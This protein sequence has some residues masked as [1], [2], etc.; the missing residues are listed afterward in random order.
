M[1]LLLPIPLYLHCRDAL[2]GSYLEDLPGTGKLSAG[3]GDLIIS[4]VATLIKVTSRLC[5]KHKLGVLPANAHS[6]LKAACQKYPP[7]LFIRILSK[8]N[9]AMR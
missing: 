6:Y 1:L 5:C 9:L 2:Q 3:Q 8:R 7:S 4:M